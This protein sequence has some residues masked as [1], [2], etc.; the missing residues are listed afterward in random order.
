MGIE[1]GA[2]YFYIQDIVVHPDYQFTFFVKQEGVP[3]GVPSGKC[4]FTTISVSYNKN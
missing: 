2:I 4:G 1:T 3:F